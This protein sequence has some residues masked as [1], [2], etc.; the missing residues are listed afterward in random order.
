MA[1][2]HTI[3]AVAPGKDRGRPRRHRHPDIGSRPSRSSSRHE[4]SPDRLAHGPAHRPVSRAGPQGGGG[5]EPRE[6]LHAPHR[7][8]AARLHG[9]L[10]DHSR[11]RI[12]RVEH[13]SHASAAPTYAAASRAWSATAADHPGRHT[14]GEGVGRGRP[15]R[16]R[17]PRPRD[18]LSRGRRR[19]ARLVGSTHSEP[20]SA[21]AQTPGRAGESR[22]REPRRG[23][24]VDHRLLGPV[25]SA[26]PWSSRSTRRQAYRSF[27]GEPQRRPAT[28][29]GAGTAARPAGS[30]PSAR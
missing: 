12:A 1:V 3:Q 8:M 24:G 26:R 10:G 4:R 15:V 27:I 7:L 21:A 22:R 11:L 5:D 20:T 19:L 25:S 18:R 23:R 2:N 17:R 28:P 16:R 14:R 29:P 6:A 9:L 13:S 30:P